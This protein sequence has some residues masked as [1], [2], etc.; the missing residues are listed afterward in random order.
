MTCH[1]AAIV[2]ALFRHIVRDLCSPSVNL[3]SLQALERISPEDRDSDWYFCSGVYETAS[4]MFKPFP[5]THKGD[6]QQRCDTTFA[7][8]AALVHLHAHL[9]HPTC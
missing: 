3:S 8:S 6:K 5:V 4:G 2:A 1:P 9:Q 7:L